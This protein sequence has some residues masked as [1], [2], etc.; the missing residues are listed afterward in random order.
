M[1]LVRLYGLHRIL[2]FSERNFPQ[3]DSRGLSDLRT[4]LSCA[5]LSSCAAMWRLQLLRSRA[6]SGLP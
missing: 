1:V 4:R 2:N 6:A 5:G 3:L